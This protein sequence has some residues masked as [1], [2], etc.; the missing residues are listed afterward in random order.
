MKRY[1]NIIFIVLAWLFSIVNTSGLGFV[2]KTPEK[3]NYIITIWFLLVLL[4]SKQKLTI[5]G[6]YSSLSFFTILLFIIIPSVS[7]NSWEGFTYLL[8]V[9]LVYCFSQQKISQFDIQ[10]TG[11]IVAALGVFTLYIYS[12]TTILAGWND[13]QIGMIGLFSYLYYAISLFGKIS[14]RKMSIGVAISVLYVILLTQNTESRSIAIFIIIA[15]IMAYFGDITRSFI[16]N[17]RFVFIA[18]SIPLFVAIAIVLFPQLEIFQAFNRWSEQNYGKSAFN[19]RDELWTYTFQNLS[20]NYYLGDGKFLINHHNSAM[21]ALGVFGVIGYICWYKLLAIPVRK[22]TYYVNDDIVFG[23]LMAFLL[24]FWQQSFDL[25][26]I[27]ASP[28]MIPYVILGVGLGRVKTIGYAKNKYN[29]T[30][31]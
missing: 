2:Y 17:K 10:S 5:G 21:A 15:L 7:V 27:S 14:F 4:R 28:N 26:F 20:N 11:Y 23:C 1:L 29:N 30:R 12:K 22:M 16:N 13:N 9:P 24:I 6:K 18:L 3:T 19:G 31:L 25:G 8:M